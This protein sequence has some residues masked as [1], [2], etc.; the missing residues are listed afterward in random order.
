MRKRV[1]AIGQFRF[2]FASTSSTSTVFF[3]DNKDIKGWKNVIRERS[4]ISRAMPA[5]EIAFSFLY[6]LFGP[7]QLRRKFIWHSIRKHTH[8][9]SSSYFIFPP[10]IS[11]FLNLNLELSDR[12]RTSFIVESSIGNSHH[13]PSEKH[14]TNLNFY[15]QPKNKL[16]RSK[17]IQNK[18]FMTQ[19][20]S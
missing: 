20:I 8:S 6:F 4:S 3:L 13:I 5:S 17:F 18:F 19:K 11:R 10:H 9:G 12:D 14:A 7:K 2:L 1:T 15:I 16:Q